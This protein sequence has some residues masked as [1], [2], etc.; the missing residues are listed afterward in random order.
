MRA[1]IEKKNQVKEQKI[2]KDNAVSLRAQAKT[3]TEGCITVVG[4]R[5][6]EYQPSKIINVNNQKEKCTQRRKK[7]APKRI[8]P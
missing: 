2:G 3:D 5:L 7:K 4:R 6:F 1:I 8:M